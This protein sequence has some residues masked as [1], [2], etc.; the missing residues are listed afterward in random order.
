M[1]HN[2]ISISTNSFPCQDHLQLSLKP[3][4]E[5]FSDSLNSNLTTSC[6]FSS[7]TTTSRSKGCGSAQRA[8]LLCARHRVPHRHHQKGK[9]VIT[10]GLQVSP[11]YH[12]SRTAETWKG[13]N[14][15]WRKNRKLELVIQYT[16]IPIFSK[17]AQFSS[18]DD[19]SH[20]GE[21]LAWR[22]SGLEFGD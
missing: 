16:S 9:W 18:Q 21:P 7:L 8:C 12:F 15:D 13:K 5:T 20:K 14:G 1:E 3:C 22:Y 6:Y 19:L 10:P 11:E 2:I 4:G 17:A